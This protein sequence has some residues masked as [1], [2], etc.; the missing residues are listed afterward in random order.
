MSVSISL[1]ELATTIGA[2]LHGAES[3]TVVSGI[4]SL[5]RATSQEVSFFSNRRY[6]AELLKTQAA[7]VIITA[8]DHTDCPVP[9]L[10]M[11]NPYLGY[12]L[13][14]TLFNPPPVKPVG[15]HP[16]AWVSPQATLGKNGYIGAHAV[17]EANAILGDNVFIGAHCVVGEGVHVGADTQLIAQVT[18]CTGTQLG[19]RVVIQPGAV[20][21]AD[22]FGL[23]NHQG[24]WIKVPQLGGVV[25]GDDVEIGA[26]T[27]IDKGALEDTIIER[28]VKLDNQIQ[29]AHNVHIGEHTAIAGC[30]G[31]AGSTRIGRY[32]MIAGGVGIVGHIEI[33]DHVHVTGGSII[34]QSILAPGVYSSGTPL[35]LNHQW[36]RNYHRFKQLDEMAKRL[37]S[38]EKTLK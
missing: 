12:A 31:I 17:I 7:A 1:A 15:I 13:A 10:L 9:V 36:H 23:A 33:V 8:K 2:E 29:I 27:T 16:T 3:S 22:G 30:V 4:N 6:R 35:E 24:E 28:G 20:I 5:V 37:T 21:G 34:L 38:L 19:K 32:C 14:A 18:L 11:N 26:N 25:V